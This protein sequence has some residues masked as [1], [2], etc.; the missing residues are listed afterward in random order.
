MNL[1]IWINTAFGVPATCYGVIVMR[2]VLKGTLR[3]KWPAIFLACSLLACVAGLLPLAGH[4]APIQDICMLSVYCS[5]AAI[6]AWLKFHLF[7]VWRPVFA[8]SIT[9]VLYLDVVTGSME[10][11]KIARI[12]SNALA[13]PSPAFHILQVLLALAL[14]VLALIAVRKCLP[15]PVK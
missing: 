15:E 1:P 6:T 11:L 2:G 12:F 3:R 9:A 10:L 8:F 14:A 13:V 7:G 4:L 5:A